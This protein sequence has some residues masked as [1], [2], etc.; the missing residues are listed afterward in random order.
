MDQRKKDQDTIKVV[1]THHNLLYK[2]SHTQE[3]KKVWEMYK[4]LKQ[5]ASDIKLYGKLQC[6]VRTL[7]TL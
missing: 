5:Y 7:C 3:E 4:I 1:T 6:S 2:Y